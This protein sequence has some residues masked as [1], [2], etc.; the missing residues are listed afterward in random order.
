MDKRRH[1][2][3]VKSTDIVEGKPKLPTADDIEYGEIAINYADGYEKLAIK[4]SVNTIRTFS[5]DEQNDSKF[6]TKQQV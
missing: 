6:A 1:L 2:L 4:S 3:H 5:T